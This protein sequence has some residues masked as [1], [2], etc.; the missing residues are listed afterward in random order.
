MFVRPA[1]RVPCH[2]ETHVS[3]TTRFPQ[4]A[5]A[6]SGVEMRTTPRFPILQRCFVY[7]AHASALQAWKCIAYNVSVA[8]IA[9]TLPI[10]LPVGTVLK[11]QAWN[12]KG[13]RSLQVRIIH[14]K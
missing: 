6:V 8:G 11:I 12:L 9:V 10:Q 14:T 7:P 13:A 5:P 3:S 4:S 2:C 1:K